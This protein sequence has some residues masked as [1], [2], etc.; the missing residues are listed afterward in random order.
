MSLSI[1]KKTNDNKFIIV[2]IYER[3]FVSLFML[4]Y[5]KYREFKAEERY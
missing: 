1:I 3:F 4:E 2:L 5:Q